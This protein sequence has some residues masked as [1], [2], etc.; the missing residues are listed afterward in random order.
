MIFSS[1]NK[2]CRW[3]LLRFFI[4]SGLNILLKKFSPFNYMLLILIILTQKSKEMIPYYHMVLVLIISKSVFYSIWDYM[5]MLCKDI[6]EH[7]SEHKSWHLEFVHTYNYD[8]R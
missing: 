1:D 8:Y 4:Y 7:N 6:V 2:I 5:L 3:G